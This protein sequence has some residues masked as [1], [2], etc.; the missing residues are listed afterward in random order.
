MFQSEVDHVDLMNV[1]LHRIEM[2]SIKGCMS[3]AFLFSST[4][5][6]SP[7]HHTAVKGTI[8]N[9]YDHL[10]FGTIYKSL[11]EALLYIITQ[12]QNRSVL[13]FS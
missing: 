13:L 6:Y 9:L 7:W 11:T 2:L 4:A 1:D 5:A 12:K 3:G 10:H 8:W